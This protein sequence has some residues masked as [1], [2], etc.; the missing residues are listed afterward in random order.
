MEWTD[1]ADEAAFRSEVRALIEE[2]L[3]A[4]YRDREVQLRRRTHRPWQGDRIAEEPERREA[5]QAWREALVERGWVAPHWPT[6]YGGAGLTV[7]EQFIL[8]QEMALADAP[9][10]GGLGTQMIG[11]TLIIHGSEEQRRQHLPEVLAG[12]VI[13]GQGYSEPGAGSDLASLATRAVRD[14]DEYV[15]NGQKIWTTLAHQADWLFVLTRTDIDAPK[16]RGISLLLME[17]ATP[18]IAIRPLVNMANEHIFNEVFFEDVRVPAENVV[19]EENRGWYVAMTL[20]DFER[21]NVAGG[22]RAQA[23]IR[24]IL[25]EARER[26]AAGAGPLTPSV[27]ALLADRYMDT[28]VVQQLSSRIAS[29]QKRG[30][31][32]NYEASMGKLFA[33]ELA[34]KV[35]LAMSKALG[36]HGQLTSPDQPRTP[37]HG[38]VGYQYM[39]SVSSTIRGGTSEIQRNVIATRGLGL[40]RS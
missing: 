5:A 31:V 21:S 38:F 26:Q 7:S 17:S 22:V 3:P 12:R 30:L 37:L 39:E 23:Q 18:G 32:P 27:R 13:W 15:V 34:Q 33:S 29:I 40:P 19:G 2:R 16:H 25:G 11:P 10:I 28:E 8:N 36:L 14:G 24:L 1:S 6:E 4:Y 20:L 9:D 35:A